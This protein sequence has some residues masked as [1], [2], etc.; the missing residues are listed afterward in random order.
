MLAS[1]DKRL[2][3]KTMLLFIRNGKQVPDS[4]VH[5]FAANDDFRY[6]LYND[7]AR[8]K[9]PALFPQRYNN[10]LD[11]AISKLLNASDYDKPDTISFIDQLPLKWANKEGLLYFFKYKRKKDDNWK[12][13]TVGLI[14]KDLN[15]FEFEKPKN[16][17]YNFDLDFTEFS[18]VKF[19]EGDPTEE[20]LQKRLKQLLYAKRSSSKEFYKGDESFED[21]VYE[22]SAR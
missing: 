11:L 19:N 9:K 15:K 7:L 18:N 2:K 14:Q 13:A 4:M 16:R 10:H 1:N 20:Q 8:L 17:S 3:Y 6:D 22:S 12:I 21:S 5:F